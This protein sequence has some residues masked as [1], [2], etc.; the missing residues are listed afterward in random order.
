M[1]YRR[2]FPVLF[3]LTF[4]IARAT[5]PDVPR[6]AD[7]EVI[8]DRQLGDPDKNP[9][10]PRHSPPINTI[11]PG[12][13]RHQKFPGGRLPSFNRLLYIDIGGTVKPAMAGPGVDMAPDLLRLIA[14]P[15]LVQRG[16]PDIYNHH[17]LQ[18]GTEVRPLTIY[19]HL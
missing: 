6:V 2:L 12:R 11:R 10:Y 19:V 13:R 18:F 4:S 16:L 15:E 8:A 7:V 17:L 5:P 14:Q 1:V 3:A 9:E